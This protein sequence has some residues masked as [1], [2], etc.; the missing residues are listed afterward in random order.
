MFRSLNLNYFFLCI[1]I[2]M[3]CKRD[4]QTTL[5][6]ADCCSRNIINSSWTNSSGIAVPIKVCMTATPSMAPSTS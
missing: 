6:V 5:N 1:Y 3:D 4:Y 2:N